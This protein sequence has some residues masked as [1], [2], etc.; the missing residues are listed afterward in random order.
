M[1]FMKNRN[2]I[3]ILIIIAITSF[4]F[5]KSNQN[6]KIDTSDWNTYENKNYGFSFKYPC[7]QECIKMK[8]QSSKNAYLKEVTSLT[9]VDKS[10]NIRVGFFTKESVDNWNNYINKLIQDPNYETGEAF[11]F[12][13][14]LER[15]TEL[16]QSQNKNSSGLMIVDSKTKKEYAYP[17]EIQ[18]LNTDESKMILLGSNN[19]F[20]LRTY[21]IPLNNDSWVEIKISENKLYDQSGVSSENL[22]RVI[23]KILETVSVF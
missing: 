2:L 15:M 7:D 8:G 18:I 19:K 16:T 12:N 5:F 3:Y 20:L 17:G 21:F 13:F 10:L 6:T 9:I 11:P 22:M 4:V 23:D 14:S 1:V